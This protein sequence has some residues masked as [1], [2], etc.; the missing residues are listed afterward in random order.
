MIIMGM[1]LRYYNITWF[2]RYFFVYFVIHLIISG[3][4]V[5]ALPSIPYYVPLVILF[6]FDIL[7]VVQGFFTQIFFE[8]GVYGIIFACLIFAIESSLS[9]VLSEP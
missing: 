1:K 8:R 4:T 2:L 7:L 9:L 6:L 5:V 3:L